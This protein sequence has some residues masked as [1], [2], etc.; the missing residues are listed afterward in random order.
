MWRLF[1]YVFPVILFAV[2]TICRGEFSEFVSAFATELET[3]TN[4]RH[5]TAANSS[6]LNLIIEI[7]P[8]DLISTISLSILAPE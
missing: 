4:E 2:G 6:A 8:Y 1:R 3:K 7:S 5:M